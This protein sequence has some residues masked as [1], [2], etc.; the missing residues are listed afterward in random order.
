MHVYLYLEV[1]NYS[2]SPIFWAPSH[3]FSSK[4]I[5]V[6]SGRYLG[7]TYIYPKVKWN[8]CMYVQ[9]HMVSCVSAIRFRSFMVGGKND[10]VK[11]CNYNVKVY[12]FVYLLYLCN[13]VGRVWKTFNYAIWVS[14]NIF[15]LI[16]TF[17]QIKVFG[18][19]PLQRC[20]MWR[21]FFLSKRGGI[22]SL[23]TQLPLRT[24]LKA[25]THYT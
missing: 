9:I 15:F 3:Q 8:H 22:T 19:I 2:F 18:I 5:F 13:G 4:R 7:C 25:I 14:E 21:F 17:N 20:I 10:T 24:P 11:N 16:L 1:I 12:V 23:R 6:L